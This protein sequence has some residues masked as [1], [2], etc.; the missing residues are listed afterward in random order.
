VQKVLLLAKEISPAPGG[1]ARYAEQ[2]AKEYGRAGFNVTLISTNAPAD[3]LTASQIIVGRRSQLLI[4]VTIFFRLLYETVIRRKRWDIVH[5]TT[6]RMALPLLPLL[7]LRLGDIRLTVH[8][9]ELLRDDLVSRFFVGFVLRKCARIIAVSSFTREL[10][11]ER[12][13]TIPPSQ[14]KV[15]HLGV[16]AP[17]TTGIPAYDGTLNIL[18]VCRQNTRKNVKAAVE[19]AGIAASS[20]VPLIYTLIGDGVRHEA[21]QQQ[22]ASTEGLEFRFLPYVDDQTLWTL[23]TRTHVYLHPQLDRRAQGD[24]EGF[25]L[26]IIDAMASGCI[27]LAGDN[28]G[29]VELIASGEDGY[30]VNPMDTTHMAKLLT[31]LAK[32]RQEMQRLAANAKLSSSKFTWN[33]HIRGVVEDWP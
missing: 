27:V 7:P 11:L 19:A 9:N 16:T 26:S 8:G 23:Y 17:K 15:A 32:D 2:V 12:F 28:A 31:S 3:E 4:G 29:P 1:I 5:A 21:L 13:T 18:T 22:A 14:V 6:W 10:L 24:V 33:N 20:G 30:L 25:G